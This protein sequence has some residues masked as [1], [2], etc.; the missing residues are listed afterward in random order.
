MF[1]KTASKQAGSIGAFGFLVGECNVE[2]GALGIE[3]AGLSRVIQGNAAKEGR[4]GRRRR[5]A[6]R[7][8]EGC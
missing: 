6:E 8:G 7:G 2:P 3:P 1:L 4:G 5:K